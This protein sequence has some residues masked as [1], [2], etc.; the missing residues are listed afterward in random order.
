MSSSNHFSGN[1]SFSSLQ[2]LRGKDIKSHH[3][4][5]LC[6]LSSFIVQIVFLPPKLTLVVLAGI[7]VD[8]KVGEMIILSKA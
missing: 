6:A 1:L 4:L 3:F 7:H 5:Q 2:G 8:V